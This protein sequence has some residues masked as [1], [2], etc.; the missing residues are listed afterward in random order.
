M[1]KKPVFPIKEPE[2]PEIKPGQKEK[3]RKETKREKMERTLKK[4][5]I[6]Y[7]E[8]TTKKKAKSL[9]CPYVNL[10]K[11]HI[12]PD[13]LN[14][15]S[16]EQA[17]ESS[18]IPFDQIEGKLLL[19]T[20]N[21]DRD[22]V[23]EIVKSFKKRGFETQIY[24]VS[25]TSLEKSL[26]GYKMTKKPVKTSQTQIKISE[27]KLSSLSKKI[28]NLQ[29]LETK[30]KT[31]PITEILDIIFAG[32][33]TTRASDIH[34]EPQKD[35]VRLRYRIDGVLHD[36]TNISKDSFKLILSRIKLLS[37]LKLNIT[38]TAQD[39]RFSIKMGSQEIN[40]RTSTLPTDFG[41]TI[42]MRILGMGIEKL[43][44]NELG[45]KEHDFTRIK[46]VLKKP[47]GMLLVTGPTGS[48][49]TTTLYSFINYINS[50]GKKIITIEDPI[51]YRIAGISQTQI[52]PDKGYDFAT[53]L[54][55]I[56]RQDPDIILVGEIRDLE[57]AEIAVNAGLTG[58]LVF[59]TLHTNDAAGAIPR[60]L[61]IGVGDILIGPALNAVIA[62]R[63][64]RRLCKY[65]KEPYRPSK[66]TVTQ[67]EKNL[68][69]KI[70]KDIKLYKP[71]GCAKCDF[72]G[73]RGRIGIFE[74]FTMNEQIEKL[75]REGVEFSEYKKEAIRSGMTTM[76][77]DGI[78]KVLQGI[79]SLEELERV[80]EM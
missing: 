41:E 32:A 6:K 66:E 77:Q 64:V 26:L 22:R 70:K 45:M 12:R 52:N 46:Q 56:V 28:K 71:K 44:V 47:N 59:S 39:G 7:E 69:K 31:L 33:L 43:K 80:T 65:C 10:H 78:E 58:H 25:K 67:L 42:V 54:G 73:Y 68:N 48:G 72:I 29:D 36:V 74:I 51:E 49:K 20:T 13:I 4:L 19:A 55:S 18:L 17:R 37:G 30:I 63:L 75:I 1:N 62:Q 76:A 50:P 21:P 11:F 27:E 53:G 23:K 9:G 61:E 57:T 15:I 35:K 16:A 5:H 8:Q 2:H 60:L 24:L 79:T 14:L 38:K 40:V 3:I 34:I